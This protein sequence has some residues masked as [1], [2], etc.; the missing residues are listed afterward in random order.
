MRRGP[1]KPTPCPGYGLRQAAAAAGTRTPPSRPLA[2]DR[3]AASS[4][5]LLPAR[6]PSSRDPSRRAARRL[7][8]ERA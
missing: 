1:A 5:R 7:R 3:D 4:P 2:L 6:L 8:P